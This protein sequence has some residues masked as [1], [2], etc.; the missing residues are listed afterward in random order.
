LK[1]EDGIG[2]EGREQYLR[3]SASRKGRIHKRFHIG[4]NPG[5]MDRERGRISKKE[6]ER[7]RSMGGPVEN[8]EREEEVDSEKG[9]GEI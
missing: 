8:Q 3:S 5:D 1:E 9:Q 6:Q 4:I 7:V 2:F